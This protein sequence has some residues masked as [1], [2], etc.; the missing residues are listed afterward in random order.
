MYGPPVPAAA[1]LGST[2]SRMIAVPTGMTPRT[3]EVLI[4]NSSDERSVRMLGDA[5][6]FYAEPETLNS[7]APAPI[8]TT[9]VPSC[10]ISALTAW[11]S[12][13]NFP[14]AGKYTTARVLAGI[15]TRRISDPSPFTFQSLTILP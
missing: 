6:G 12:S 1:C 13:V 15:E 2:Y 11:W 7:Y 5:W 3:T 9:R 8:E 14:F 10:L 4:G